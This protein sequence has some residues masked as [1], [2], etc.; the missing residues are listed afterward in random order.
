MCLLL[1]GRGGGEGG[2]RTWDFRAGFRPDRYRPLIDIAPRRAKT[3]Q[4]PILGVC[5]LYKDSTPKSQ[6]RGLR[7][8]PGLRFRAG[9]TLPPTVSTLL[10]SSA[11]MSCAVMDICRY[12]IDRSRPQ[13]GLKL[14]EAD[15][16]LPGPTAW[17]PH[18]S[19]T[20]EAH[21]VLIHAK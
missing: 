2:G 4:K 18:S 9:D 1:G 13:V 6:K 15:G 11:S 21:R 10:L 20:W 8:T 3:P 19:M 17:D 7:T 16:G 5:I 14:F 12:G